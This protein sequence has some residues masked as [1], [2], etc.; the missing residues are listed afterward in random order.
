MNK[1]LSK[2]H[3][4]LRLLE[5]HY[6]AKNLPQAR[7]N[8]LAEFLNNLDH[9]S[10]SGD[11]WSARCPHHADW[12]PSLS[13]GI[14][15]DG[16]FLVTCHRGCDFDDIVRDAGMLPSEMFDT[17]PSTRSAILPPRR[18]R[19]I[20][21][22][23]TAADSSWTAMQSSFRLQADDTRLE[24]LASE[25]AVTVASLRSIGV[26]WC[27]D[28]RVWTFPE[29]NG[30]QAICGILR[31][32]P[33]G[34]KYAVKGGHRGLTLPSHWRHSDKC[35]HICEGAS[36]VAAAVS[37]GMRAIGRPGLRGGFNDLAI[38]LKG[39]PAEI[40]MVADNDTDGVGRNGAGKLAQRLS[41]FLKRPIN[42]MAPP[43]QFKDL[44]E[45]LTEKTK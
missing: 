25:L 33:S 26:G 17:V 34:D 28:R 20:I 41:D 35:L 3:G 23:A 39:E 22:E 40:V 2:N 27:S 7:F 19:N 42:V 13:V 6:I 29:R 9:V 8:T 4:L 1:P 18:P 14:G 32:S 44:R 37:V 43:K 5:R 16:T 31:R 45:F 15:A 36:D 11:G 10:E 38:L 30:E 24:Q 21:P 12:R